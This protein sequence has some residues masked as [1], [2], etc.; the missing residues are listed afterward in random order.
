METKSELER[1]LVDNRSEQQVCLQTESSLSSRWALEE[2]EEEKEKEE[3]DGRRNK[4]GQGIKHEH[5]RGTCI[6]KIVPVSPTI[7]SEV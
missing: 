2:K 3:V 4:L 5:G 1:T 6:L 7:P